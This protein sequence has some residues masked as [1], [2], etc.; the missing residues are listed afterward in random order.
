MKMRISSV[1]LNVIRGSTL[2][3]ADGTWEIVMLLTNWTV[4]KSSKGKDHQRAEGLPNP[5]A[6]YKLAHVPKPTK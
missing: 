3:N 4:I 2:K 5:S 1:T 6:Q